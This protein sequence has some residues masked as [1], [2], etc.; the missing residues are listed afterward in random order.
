M[1]SDLTAL[2]VQH[3]ISCP[4]Y[5]R[6]NLSWLRSSSACDQQHTVRYY[7]LTACDDLTAGR[8]DGSYQKRFNSKKALLILDDWGM[9]ELTQEH[10]GHLL[11]A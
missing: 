3:G 11:S 2:P 5:G 4:G 9:E 6:Q 8:L 1:K 7:R 10:A